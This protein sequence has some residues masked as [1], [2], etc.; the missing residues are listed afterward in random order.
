MQE[1][2][3]CHQNPHVH[4]VDS[5]GLLEG[6]KQEERGGKENKKRTLEGDGHIRIG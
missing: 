3:L 2:D 6:G 5:S 1:N 4:K